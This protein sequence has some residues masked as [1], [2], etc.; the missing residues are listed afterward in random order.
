M[1]SQEIIKRCQRGEKDAF[2][3]LLSTIEK[4]ALATAYLISGTRGIAED[5]LQE[6]YIKCFKDIDKLKNPEAF[7]V[8]F[9]KI[10]VRTGWEMTKKHSYLMPMDMSNHDEL[11]LNNLPPLQEDALDTY[12]TKYIVQKAVNNLSINLKTV[13]ILYYFNDMSIEEIAKVVGCLKATV[14]SRL[15]YARSLLKK[16]LSDEF[17]LEH[18]FR[19]I[20]ERKCSE[21]G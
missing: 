12:E 4:D 5:I 13:V 16:E 18:D 15:F 20:S 19:K 3:E 9:F 7:K 10:L 2:K 17:Y 21:N 6:T 1:D 14:K 8:W 11:L